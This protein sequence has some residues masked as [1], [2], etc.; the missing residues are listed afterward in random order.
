MNCYAAL[1]EPAKRGCKCDLLQHQSGA[2]GNC[3]VATQLSADACPAEAGAPPPRC[4]IRAGR[5]R[6]PKREAA[7]GEPPHGAATTTKSE[8]RQRH[9]AE[10]SFAREPHVPTKRDRDEPHKKPLPERA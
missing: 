5:E 10:A 8:R 1:Q 6:S 3:G 2:R 9:V 4:E 7:R